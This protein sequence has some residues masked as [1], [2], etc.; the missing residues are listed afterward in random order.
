VY[1]YLVTCEIRSTNFLETRKLH[2]IVSI[3]YIDILSVLRIK[4][5]NCLVVTKFD[6]TLLRGVG[7]DTYAYYLPSPF[8]R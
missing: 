5:C 1:V 4:S 6:L 2:T 8:K 3:L 7:F